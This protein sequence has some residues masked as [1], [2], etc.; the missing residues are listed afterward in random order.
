VR[1]AWISYR[2]GLDATS[3][4]CTWNEG[5]WA[6]IH[7]DRKSSAGGMITAMSIQTSTGEYKL[8]VLFDKE[9]LFTETIETIE[10]CTAYQGW[11]DEGLALSKKR[12]LTSGEKERYEEIRRLIQQEDK[13]CE[14]VQT[15]VVI[16]SI[17]DGFSV[18]FP[19][20]GRTNLRRS[21][22]LPT[23]FQFCCF[24]SLVYINCFI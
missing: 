13:R 5:Q 17:K 10:P 16:Q 3:M 19:R 12:N 11:T 8:K 18:K 2:A 21:G 15:E 6:P 1:K 4:G 24:T 14:R 22:L 9:D 20:A 7:G 23:K